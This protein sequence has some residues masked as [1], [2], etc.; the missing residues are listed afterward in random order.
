MLFGAKDDLTVAAAFF[1]GKMKKVSLAINK[2]RLDGPHANILGGI[3]MA[4]I[5][6]AY[7]KHIVLFINFIGLDEGNNFEK[8]FN[9]ILGDTLHDAATEMD[10]TFVNNIEFTHNI[11]SQ[12]KNKTAWISCQANN[13]NQINTLLPLLS[14]N[15]LGD[16]MDMLIE[17][18]SSIKYV[19]GVSQIY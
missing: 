4:A 12:F 6:D 5:D 17:V 10:V 18:Q 14:L 19:S 9:A 15:Y 3:F 13:H 11:V 8:W 7:I 2:A 16:M 1:S